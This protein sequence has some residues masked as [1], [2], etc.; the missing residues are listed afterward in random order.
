V[1]RVA[2][3]VVSSRDEEEWMP[4]RPRAAHRAALKKQFYAE[5]ELRYRHA[6]FCHW[7]EAWQWKEALLRVEE[8]NVHTHESI[9]K[10]LKVL[11]CFNCSL[12]SY[13]SLSD[14]SPNW[15]H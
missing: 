10:Y 3:K 6:V 9:H 7:V 5:Y 11:V 15:L 2:A 13:S 14:I 8:Q 12:V 1:Q 4:T